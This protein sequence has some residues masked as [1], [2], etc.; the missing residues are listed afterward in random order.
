MKSLHY[1]FTLGLVGFLSSAAAVEP[2]ATADL[3]SQCANHE[4]DPASLDT[5]RCRS[6]LQGYMGGAYAM[7]TISV[8]DEIPKKR[9]DFIE[10]AQRTRIGSI[11]L[12]YGM[13]N[14]AGYCVPQDLTISEFV[15]RLN[16]FAAIDGKRSELA[17]Q[18]V[19]DFLRK[20]FDCKAAKN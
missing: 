6:Y 17:N 2:L 8:T 3:L 1:L 14:R 15:A 12:R 20:E 9:S 19:L 13:N 11:D 18:F 16:R 5:A 7:R 10:R 4:K